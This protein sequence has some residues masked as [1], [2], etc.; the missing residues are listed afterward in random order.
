MNVSLKMSLYNNSSKKSRTQ[1][2]D[3]MMDVPKKDDQNLPQNFEWLHTTLKEDMHME[4]EEL[5]SW[6]SK[7][8]EPGSGRIKT[9]GYIYDRFLLEPIW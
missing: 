6:I 4:E 7:S 2:R 8:L 3:Y 9:N 1:Q 5:W